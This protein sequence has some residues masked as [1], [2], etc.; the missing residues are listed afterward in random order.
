MNKFRDDQDYEINKYMQA[1]IKPVQLPNV[2]STLRGNA[3]NDE[4]GS[5]SPRSAMEI[6]I[7][8]NLITSY[9]D[10]VRKSMNDIVP[11]TVIA[12]LINKTKNSAQ[13]ELVQN[14]YGDGSE[15]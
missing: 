6:T 7:I 8:K 9:F 4:S 15:L 12:F 5:N 11:K 13:R 14:I 10:I 3:V 1:N 2:P